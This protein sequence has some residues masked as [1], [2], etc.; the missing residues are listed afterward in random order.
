[1]LIL[2]FVDSDV[3]NVIFKKWCYNRCVLWWFFSVMILIIEFELLNLGC[4]KGWYYEKNFIIL[5]KYFWNE[6]LLIKY[7]DFFYYIIEWVFLI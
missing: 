1:M 5:K 6:W 3:D 4:Y 7:L 2:L